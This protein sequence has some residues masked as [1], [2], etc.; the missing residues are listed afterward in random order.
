[1]GH[2]RSYLRALGDEQTVEG[3]SL[4]WALGEAVWVRA[5]VEGVAAAAA[6][7][8]QPFGDGRRAEG[9]IKRLFKTEIRR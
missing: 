2:C 5:D 1:M 6:A 4:K 3:E 8:P 9:G 7:L